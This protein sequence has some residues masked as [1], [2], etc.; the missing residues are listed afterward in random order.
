MQKPLPGTQEGPGDGLLKE[1]ICKST[2]SPAVTSLPHPPHLERKMKTWACNPHLD[3]ILFS[4]SMKTKTITTK[5]KKRAYLLLIFRLC[6]KSR[7]SWGKVSPFSMGKGGAMG[8]PR[9]GLGHSAQEHHSG[10]G[11]SSSG[12]GHPHPVERQ[13][14]RT[15]LSVHEEC[16]G[17]F[18]T[19]LLRISALV[20]SQ[21]PD[22]LSRQT[23]PQRD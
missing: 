12:G 9:A 10:P 7:Q 18:S 1:C 19:R 11:L 8:A 16:R 15:P 23:V 13:V 5:T 2:E 14:V 6:R 3:M 17:C 4:F 20:S 21:D 22:P